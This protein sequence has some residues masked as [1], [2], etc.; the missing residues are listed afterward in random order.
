MIMEWNINSHNKVRR[1]S[2][3][4]APKTLLPHLKHCRRTDPPA[5]SKMVTSV[6][7]GAG[8]ANSCRRT[9][10][11]VPALLTLP[12]HPG[13]CRRTVC[14]SSYFKH[15]DPVQGGPP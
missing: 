6:G 10:Q 14:P 5:Q 8:T 11:A 12:L 9:F 7:I 1:R 15:L 4:P 2:A 13:R 3:V